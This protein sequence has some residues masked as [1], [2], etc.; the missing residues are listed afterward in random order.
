MPATVA[1]RRARAAGS[2]K[3]LLG[4]GNAYAL[5]MAWETGGR[6]PCA[7]LP[8]LTPESFCSSRACC[9]WRQRASAVV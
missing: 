9:R 8:M 6:S 3:G 5:P 2:S 1:R 7:G 4:S